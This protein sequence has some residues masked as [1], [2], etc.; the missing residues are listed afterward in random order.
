MKRQAK[1]NGEIGA[2]GK[3][4]QK[5]QFIAEQE[6]NNTAAATRFAKSKNKKVPITPC[7]WVLASEIPEGARTIYSEVAVFSNLRD[8]GTLNE[9]AIA[10]HNEDF[11]KIESLTLRYIDGERYFYP[12]HEVYI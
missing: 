5:G 9:H 12:D 7:E 2:N 11:K 3:A 10:F 6:V 1:F 8:I 4:Y